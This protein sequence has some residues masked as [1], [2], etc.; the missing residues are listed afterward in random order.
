MIKNYF[1]TLGLR[2][3]LWRFM[4]APLHAL[5]IHFLAIFAAREG[6]DNDP[7]TYVFYSF[8][9]PWFFLWFV[10]LFVLPR[11][12]PSKFAA[13]F[14][15]QKLKNKKNEEKKQKT[16]LTKPKKES[17]KPKK[18]ST[19]Q[20]QLK[21][22]MD[23]LQEETQNQ[24]QSAIN[25]LSEFD[26][27]SNCVIDVIEGDAFKM[28]LNK[29]EK[30]ILKKGKTYIQKFVKLSSFLSSKEKNLQHMFKLLQSTTISVDSIE[31]SSFSRGKVI[32]S[33]NSYYFTDV[34]KTKFKPEY[35]HYQI[36]DDKVFVPLDPDEYKSSLKRQQEFLSK[37]IESLKDEIHTYN[38]LV[39]CSL[40]MIINLVDDEMIA[41]YE[42]YE[43]FDQLN[44]FKSKHETDMT[45]NLSR[46]KFGIDNMS[47]DLRSIL[48]AVNKMNVQIYTSLENL[49]PVYVT[50]ESSNQISDR[51]KEINSSVQ[52][53]NRINIINAYLNYKSKRL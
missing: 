30:N 40:S 45:E 52:M 24:L 12:V 34:F 10:Y 23:L 38:L 13:A 28:L 36:I 5:A 19:K 37:K 33:D 46:I 20:N 9:V 35:S 48:A 7:D 25:S 31:N 2:P 11:L 49:I 39:F 16:E 27:D 47:Y 53:G 29:H 43:A 32:D 4:I 42:I 22:E 41:F 1:L 44:I 15:A 18:E 21:K 8:I 17:T 6:Y 51:L 26:K 50:E 14:A 3:W